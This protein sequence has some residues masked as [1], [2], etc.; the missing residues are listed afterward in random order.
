[1]ARIEM[2]APCC[3]NPDWIADFRLELWGWGGG[4]RKERRENG[5]RR[6]VGVFLDV[7]ALFPC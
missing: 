2:A 6:E 4:E 5:N 3:E 7:S 1:M